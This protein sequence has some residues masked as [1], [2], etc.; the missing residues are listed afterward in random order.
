MGMR[1]LDTCVLGLL[2]VVSP[3]L[4]P[5]EAQDKLTMGMGGGT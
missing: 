4:R 2:L 5:A 3:G 1:R